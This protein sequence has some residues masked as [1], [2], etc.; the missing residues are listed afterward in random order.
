M[1]KDIYDF[2]RKF[3]EIKNLGYVKSINEDN[4]GIGLT[5]EK[6]LGKKI[7]NF[8]LPDYKNTF[9]IKAKLAYSKTPIHLFKLTPDG[10]SFLETKRILEKYGYYQMTSKKY[11]VFNGQINSKKYNK[12][13]YYYFSI[14]VNYKNERVEVIVKDKNQKVIDSSTYWPFDK[15]ENALIRK[16]KYLIIVYVWSTSKNKETYY[17]YYRYNI[18]KLSNFINFIHLIDIGIVSITFSIDYYK[19]SARYGQVHDHGTSFDIGIDNVNK[20][21]HEID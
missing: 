3:Y 2:K 1:N 18:F 5:L 16:L 6:L 11:K 13:G 15:L 7:D 14:N 8:P 12:I 19:N 20:L 17:K 21:Y 10:N 9:E 4:S